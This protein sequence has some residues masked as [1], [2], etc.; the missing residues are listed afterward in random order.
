MIKSANYNNILQAITLA[1]HPFVKRLAL[2][3]AAPPCQ[4]LLEIVYNYI[5]RAAAS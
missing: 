3:L 2:A 5:A 4:D 1:K